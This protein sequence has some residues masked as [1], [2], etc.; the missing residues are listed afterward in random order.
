MLSHH[1]PYPTAIVNLLETIGRLR[2]PELTRADVLT[3]LKSREEAYRRQLKGHHRGRNSRQLAR[4][5]MLAEVE[6][7]IDSELHFLAMCESKRCKAIE[8]QA[9]CNTIL[10]RPNLSTEESRAEFRKDYIQQYLR[11][12]DCHPLERSEAEMRALIVRMNTRRSR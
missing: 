7:E 9:L 10:G 11:A 6:A 5:L 1:S 8:P 3:D 2:S 4:E 12:A